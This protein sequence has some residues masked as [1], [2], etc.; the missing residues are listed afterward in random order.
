MENEELPGKFLD[1]YKGKFGEEFFCFAL[2]LSKQV[3]EAN[4]S[5]EEVLRI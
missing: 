4:E 3:G 2:Q 5:P 1:L